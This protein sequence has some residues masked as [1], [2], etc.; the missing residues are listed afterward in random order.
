VVDFKMHHLFE[1]TGLDAL[2]AAKVKKMQQL[3][4]DRLQLE[5]DEDG[6]MHEIGASLKV[7]HWHASGSID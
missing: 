7:A 5:S 3:S 2:V 4:E 1:S 6:G